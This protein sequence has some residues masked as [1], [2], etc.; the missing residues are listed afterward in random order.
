MEICVP[1]IEES[2]LAAVP[3]RRNVFLMA[4]DNVALY[5]YTLLFQLVLQLCGLTHILQHQ[6]SSFWMASMANDTDFGSFMEGP[7]VAFGYRILKLVGD[8]VI[9]ICVPQIE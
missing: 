4:R 8:S 2:P 7:V 9:E 1:Q 6:T 5:C 3:A